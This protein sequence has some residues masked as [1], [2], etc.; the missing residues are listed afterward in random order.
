MHGPAYI[1]WTNLT[2]CS[3]Q[4]YYS[5]ALSAVNIAST[6]VTASLREALETKVNLEAQLANL[7]APEWAITV[8]MRYID[9]VH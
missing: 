7:Y 4:S 9:G 1:V 3:L 5:A 8:V 2:H 6:Q